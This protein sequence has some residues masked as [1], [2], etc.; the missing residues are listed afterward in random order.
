MHCWFFVKS[1]VLSVFS[2]YVA[3][4]LPVLKSRKYVLVSV[5]WMV[6][7]IRPWASLMIFLLIY[8]F[9]VVSM[10]PRTFTGAIRHISPTIHIQFT[11]HQINGIWRVWEETPAPANK[12]KPSFKYFRMVRL[13]S[14]GKYKK[15][16]MQIF[17]IK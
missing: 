3:S 16:E 6:A 11:K 13:F 5:S 10:L 2:L 8:A 15:P 1:R 7:R 9:L 14:R 4:T 12:I 17:E